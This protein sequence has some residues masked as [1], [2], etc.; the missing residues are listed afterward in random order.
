V[1]FDARRRRISVTGVAA[2]RRPDG[3][4]RFVV[5]ARDPGIP[6][7]NWLDTGGRHRGFVTFRWL[8]NPEPPEIATR[9]VPLDEVVHLP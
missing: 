4:V 5:A 9:V 3:G 8:D 2:A 6:T 1:C 7:A